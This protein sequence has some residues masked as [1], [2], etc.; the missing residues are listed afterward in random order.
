MLRRLPRSFA[1]AEVLKVLF[2]IIVALCILL[3]FYWI[4]A[5]SLKNQADAFSV[6][7][8]LFFKPTFEYYAALFQEASFTRYFVNSFVICAGSVILALI[9]GVPAAYAFARTDF[10]GSKWVFNMLLV[11]RMSPGAVFVIPYF[12]SYKE[13]GMLDTQIGL[14]L[15]YFALNLGI[16]VWTMR[17]FF[18]D[19]PISLEEAAQIDGCTTMT[20]LLRIVLPLSTPGL[21]ATSII[22]FIFSWNEFLI[23]LILTRKEALTAPVGLLNFMVFEKVDWGPIAAGSMVISLP[24]IIF[25]IAI[26][27]YFVRGLSQGAFGGE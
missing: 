14:L 19:I 10:P 1:A 11:T 9:V 13:L 12:F 22:A 2:I 20:S 15:I 8:K 7:P 4:L 25:G 5:V 24:V 27:K 26:R 23:A 21:A 18:E 16:V 6:S 17:S 3:P